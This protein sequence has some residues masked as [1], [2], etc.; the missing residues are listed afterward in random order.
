VILGIIW[1]I[2]SRAPSG[3][4]KPVK[5]L[6]PV[7]SKQNVIPLLILISFIFLIT[8]YMLF[9]KG[10][11]NFSHTNVNPGSSSHAY[12]TPC[13]SNDGRTGLYNTKGSCVVCSSGVAVTRSVGN[14]SSAV[15]GVYC[16]KTASVN[17]GGGKDRCA[18]INAAPTHCGPRPPE[19]CGGG[20][21]GECDVIGVPTYLECDC[22]PGT[23]FKPGTVID[24]VTPGGPWK[25]CT[26]DG[27]YK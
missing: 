8:G 26:C 9:Q 15:S 2:I 6:A 21:V 3:R 25:I 4:T 10:Y 14:C 13:T 18:Q 11:I 22:P 19:E 23:F 1:K 7:K 12:G 5:Q 27:P 17:V 24:R 20:G 16:C